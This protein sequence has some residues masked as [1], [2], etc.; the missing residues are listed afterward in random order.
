MTADDFV[1]TVD[2]LTF[3]ENGR[4]WTLEV[5]DIDTSAPDAFAVTVCIPGIDRE[6]RFDG[7]PDDQF[8]DETALRRA[9]IGI[10]REIVAGRQAKAFVHPRG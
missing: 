2:G 7:I 1:A 10:A 4:T 3:E 5:D 8:V 9:V 6:M